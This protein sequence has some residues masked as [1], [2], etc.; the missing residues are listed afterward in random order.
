MRNRIDLFIVSGFVLFLEL[1][2]I[3]WFPAQVLF[4]TFFTNTVLLRGVSLAAPTT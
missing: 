3:R 4:L 2:S 1:A